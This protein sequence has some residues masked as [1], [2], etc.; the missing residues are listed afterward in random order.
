MTARLSTSSFEVGI[1]VVAVDMM[2]SPFFESAEKHLQILEAS[3]TIHFSLKELSAVLP[4]LPI[5][6]HFFFLYQY[7]ERRAARSTDLV[8]FFGSI[9]SGAKKFDFGHLSVAFRWNC[10][11]L[12]SYPRVGFPRQ[13]VGNWMGNSRI[14]RETRHRRKLERQLG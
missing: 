9:C 6:W 14:T 5:E 4:R 1:F 10:C 7:V 3:P 2:F 12:R 11:L 8:S 13:L